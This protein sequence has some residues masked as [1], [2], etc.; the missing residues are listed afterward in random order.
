M[1]V[2]AYTRVSSDK[3]DLHQQELSLAYPLTEP[4]VSP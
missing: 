4:A 1:Q 3:Q 2:I